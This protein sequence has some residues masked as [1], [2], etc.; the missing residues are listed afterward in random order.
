[1]NEMKRMMKGEM[2]QI[3]EQLDHIESNQVDQPRNTTNGHQRK[4][5]QPREDITE[6]HEFNHE[7][8]DEDDDNSWWTVLRSMEKGR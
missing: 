7:G 4:K 8:F 1:M 2:D 6:N 3:H 5:C